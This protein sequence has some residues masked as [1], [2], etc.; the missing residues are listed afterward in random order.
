M[1]ARE[2]MVA[3][4]ES[5]VS[6][7]QSTIVQRTPSSDS[8]PPDP[9]TRVPYEALGT[10]KINR[11][12]S[13]V[14]ML[15][16]QPSKPLSSVDT[17]TSVDT[18]SSVVVD[19][20]KASSTVTVNSSTLLAP[21][22]TSVSTQTTET[23]FAL[24]VKCSDTHRALVELAQCVSEVTTS[25]DMTC[26]LGGVDWAGLASVGGLE[27]G[28]WTE[29]FR[30]DLESLSGHATGLEV[31]VQGLREQLEGQREVTIRM[32][33]EI[34]SLTAQVNALQVSKYKV[35]LV[36]QSEALG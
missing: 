33:G 12:S 15:S 9:V 1:C 26:S 25:H 31:R 8:I 20:S 27:I 22:C 34:E 23:G 19:H 29:C 2:E 28:R 16:Q 13:S 10:M 11:L 21:Q 17:R 4:L 6:D 32:E 5:T 30:R 7:L 24:C 14:D 18:R 3:S 35:A 36:V